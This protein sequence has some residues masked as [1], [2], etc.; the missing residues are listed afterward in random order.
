MTTTDRRFLI[1]VGARDFPFPACVL[2]R[3]V[4]EGQPTVL[5]ISIS[6]RIMA[7]FE[8][9]WI[10]TFIQ[11]LHKHRDCIGTATLA[12]N[13]AD[14]VEALQASA[15]TVTFDFPFFYEKTTP[16]SGEKCLVRYMC[17]YTVKAVPVVGGPRVTLKVDI[18]VLT[19]YPAS[20]PEKKG[21]LFAQLS[22]MSLEVEPSRDIFPEDLIDLVDRHALVPV[23]SFLTEDDQAYLI[24]KA[25]S[26]YKPSVV[27]VDEV[28]KELARDRGIAWYSVASANYGMLHSYST[29]ISTERSMWVPFSCY[30]EDDI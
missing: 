11:V 4:P 8:A 26:D 5:D 19:T 13:V 14:Y 29:V 6:A 28:K 24:E 9:R 20:A 12:D 3:V 15:I 16:V 10:D 22:I 17:A 23:Y 27:V 1:S 7:E 30:D 25:H 21:G 2:S 18:P